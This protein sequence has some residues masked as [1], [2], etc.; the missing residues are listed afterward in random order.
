MDLAFIHE[1]HELGGA[2]F[3]PWNRISKF[4]EFIAIIVLP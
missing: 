1:G 4:H 2:G 3:V